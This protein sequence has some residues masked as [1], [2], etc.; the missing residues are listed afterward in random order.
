VF[1]NDLNYVDAFAFAKSQKLVKL[2]PHFTVVS[3][4]ILHIVDTNSNVIHYLKQLSQHSISFF[5][6][7]LVVGA[8]GIVAISELSCV[9][10]IDV[11]GLAG[12]EDMFG[13]EQVE[14]FERND[15]L[16]DYRVEQL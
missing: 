8:K 11:V 13:D 2:F 16:F 12:D 14:L 4:F 7:L 3:Q 6:Y 10:F 15:L 5:D 9:K 1:S